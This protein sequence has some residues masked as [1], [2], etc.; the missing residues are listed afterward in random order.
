M[1]V[2]LK[3]EV[4]AAASRSRND[5]TLK[6]LRPVVCTQ[7]TGE[8][9]S[10]RIPIQCSPLTNCHAD[11]RVSRLFPFSCSRVDVG[12]GTN[13]SAQGP[14]Q[15]LTVEEPASRKKLAPLHVSAG[16]AF[17]AASDSEARFRVLC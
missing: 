5:L 2:M 8:G 13:E 15:L 6:I 3:A 12:D 4:A 9:E 1:T 11:A 10:D 7:S 17:E 16:G 14:P